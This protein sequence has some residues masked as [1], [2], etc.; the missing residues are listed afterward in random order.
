[1]ED[2]ALFHAADSLFPQDPI[3][4]SLLS[5]AREFGKKVIV[6]D[7]AAGTEATYNQLITDIIHAQHLLRQ[8]LLPYLD[9]QGRIL[10][11]TYHIGVLAPANYEFVVAAFAILALGGTVVALPVT[12]SPE[13][14]LDDYLRTSPVKVILYGTR[15]RNQATHLQAY[16]P[17]VRRRVFT[18]PTPTLN[19]SIYTPSSTL[20]TDLQTETGTPTDIGAARQSPI[21]ATR[22]GI[23]FFSSGSTG[24]PKGVI[25][26][27]AIFHPLQRAAAD[28][29]QLI[30]RAASWITGSLPLIETLLTGARAEIVEPTAG[31]E[32]VWERV[33]QRRVTALCSS[34]M[35]FDEMAAYWKSH[36]KQLPAAQRDEYKGGLKCLTH[37]AIGGSMP[38]PKLLRFWRQDL[39]VRLTVMYGSTETGGKGLTV[40]WPDDEVEL[41]RNLGKQRFPSRPIK[42]SERDHGELLVGGL[43]TFLGYLNGPD[44]TDPRIF[45]AEGYYKTGD[46]AHKVGEYYIFDGRASIDF[47]KTANGPVPVQLVEQTLSSLPCIETGYV[48]PVPDKL[49][50]RR[51]GVI[52]RF[53]PSPAEGDN[54]RTNGI[55]IGKDTPKA[56]GLLTIRRDLAQ[57]GHLPAHMLPTAFRMLGENERLPLTLSA[58]VLKERVLEQFFPL[59]PSGA[60]LEDVEVWTG[61]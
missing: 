32:E 14:I 60:F 10:K 36:I 51:V 30:Y 42:L 13:T 39:G 28:E 3:F 7:P 47:I 2:A 15:F 59:S 23:V 11:S 31:P 52:A 20:S 50:G 19:Q 49:L 55:R 8:P 40:V 48:V 44:A 4:T 17:A 34:V 53:V 58:K 61:A 46:I 57:L 25:H 38:C 45:N 22:P 37:T 54:S 18:A 12:V 43:T 1:M 35:L 41:D 26:S 21:P 56:R 27:R 5:L 9:G 24:T 6:H 33:R 16:D 29:G